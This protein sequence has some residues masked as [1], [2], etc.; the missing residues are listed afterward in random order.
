MMRIQLYFYLRDRYDF[1]YI[2]DD[3]YGSLA[4]KEIIF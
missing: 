1:D 2:N 3:G 4:K